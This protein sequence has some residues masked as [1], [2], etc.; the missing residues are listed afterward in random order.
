MDKQAVRVDLKEFMD[1]AKKLGD[2]EYPRYLAKAFQYLSMRARNE[3][4]HET[5]SK[6]KLHTEFI[7]N[8][9]LNT[10][11]TAGQVKAAENSIRQYHDI[12]S[13]VFLRPAST[14]KRDLGFMVPH[15]TGERKV[16]RH[17]MLAIPAGDLENYDYKTSRGSVKSQYKPKNLLKSYNR[18]GGNTKGHKL[19]GKSG[20][21]PKPFLLK[22]GSGKEMV[23]RR[24]AK[25]SNRLEF[26]YSLKSSARIDPVWS[27]EET[28]KRTVQEVYKAVIVG[29]LRK[30]KP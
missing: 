21:A 10:P 28:V 27:F 14:P 15:E 24:Q 16:P 23:V 22:L 4:R 7:P 3:V 20:G 18:V 9:I 19:S 29:Q 17:G 11:H 8:S 2:S 5:K 26:L 30:M 6:F 25:T 12:M 13:A 1:S